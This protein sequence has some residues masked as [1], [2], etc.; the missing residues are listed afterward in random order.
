MQSYW[1]IPNPTFTPH[2]MVASSHKSFVLCPFQRPLGKHPLLNKLGGVAA[3]DGKWL[4]VLGDDC[5]IG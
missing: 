2:E 5:L 1:N 4:D 3:Y